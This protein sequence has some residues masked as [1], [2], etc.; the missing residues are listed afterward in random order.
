MTEYAL[1]EAELRLAELRAPSAPIAT[2]PPTLAQLARD[3]VEAMDEQMGL[4]EP[5]P[6]DLEAACKWSRRLWEAESD[7]APG[8]AAQLRSATNHV[9]RLTRLLTRAR[10]AHAE[11]AS[12]PL[13][14][15]TLDLAEARLRAVEASPHAPQQVA[16]LRREMA[17]A[18]RT[19]VAALWKREQA[20]EPPTPEFID[21][22]CT[23]SR[24]LGTAS[25][26][27]GTHLRRM[28]DLH[29]DMKRR[30]EQ[31]LEVSRIQVSQAEYYLREAAAPRE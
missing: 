26:D 9:T 11:D 8:P 24:R 29:A 22:M 17:D 20:G 30:F 21:A 27:P 7:T 2:P 16:A 19:H 3:V 6:E 28:R 23:A 13:E 10:A 12:F 4:I 18:A 15:I 5:G 25:G 31:G 1:R 14:G